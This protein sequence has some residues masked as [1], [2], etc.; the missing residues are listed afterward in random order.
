MEC[1]CGRSVP[2]LV[3]GLCPACYMRKYRKGQ[4]QRPEPPEKVEETL[5]PGM[6]HRIHV[7]ILQGLPPVKF[8]RYVRGIITQ[9]EV[10][11]IA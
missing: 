7:L 5:P 4:T 6:S 11:L 9:A 1:S 10:D 8:A 2:K 3:A